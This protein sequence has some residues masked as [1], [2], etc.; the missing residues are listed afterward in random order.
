MDLNVTF[1]VTVCSLK[2]P[3]CHEPARSNLEDSFTSD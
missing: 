1:G 2:L 3:K